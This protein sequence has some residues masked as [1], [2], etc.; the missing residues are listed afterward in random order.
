MDDTGNEIL[1]VEINHIPQIEAF[2]IKIDTHP[3]LILTRDGF[4]SGKI[5]CFVAIKQAALQCCIIK[6]TL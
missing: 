5:N 1:R 4:L 2:V 3:Y 6:N